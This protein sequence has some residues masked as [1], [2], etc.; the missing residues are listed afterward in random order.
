MSK[1]HQLNV[2]APMDLEHGQDFHE[3][4]V[5]EALTRLKLW[6]T[7]MGIDCHL[8]S[9]FNENFNYSQTSNSLREL[10]KLELP[11]VIFACDVALRQI[12]GNRYFIIEDP[13]AGEVQAVA[14]TANTRP[15]ETSM[16]LVCS[17]WH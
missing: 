10:R 1:K 5:R 11:L 3:Q 8:W 14:T 13:E 7:V 15:I 17:H 2:L 16:G 4:H 12:S 9:L 6:L